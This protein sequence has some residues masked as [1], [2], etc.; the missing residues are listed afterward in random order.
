MRKHLMVASVIAVAL[1]V[2]QAV[3]AES[4]G[5]IISNWVP[6]SNNIDDSGCPDGKNADAQKIMAYTL[7]NQGMADDQ[8][9][10]ATAPETL[11]NYFEE[12]APMRGRK[13]GK[14]VNVYSHPLSVPDPHIKL[15]QSKQAYG[16]NLDGKVGS[17]D[18]T[19]P[20]TQEAGIDNMAARVFGCFDRTRGTIDTPPAN[21]TYRFQNYLAGGHTW[22]LEITNS[23]DRPLDFQNEKNVTVTFYRSPQLPVRSSSGLQR[24][25][26]YTIFPE[27]ETLRSFKG[28]I[29]NGMFLSGVTKQFK[30]TGSSSIQPVYDFKQARMRIT[31]KPDGRLLGFVGGYL[32]IRMIYFP[33]GEYATSAEI[34]GSMDVAG[35]YQA[36]Q[37]NADTDIDKVGKV[38]TRISQTYQML[39]VPAYLIREPKVAMALRVPQ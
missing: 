31:F 26:T 22:L 20:L 4:K 29:K 25:V 3:H 28:E 5:Y 6:A 16:F 32:P 18:Y 38:R 33:F 23:S 9:V 11:L 39:A 10:K 15:D 24:D 35:M 34:Q 17:T 12:N 2:T 36:L 13:D 8:I 1:G 21:W 37:Q 27:R 7:K 30:M 19:D 14:P